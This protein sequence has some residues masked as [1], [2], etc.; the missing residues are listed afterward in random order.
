[1]TTKIKKENHKMS[2]KLVQIMF[3][4]GAGSKVHNYLVVSDIRFR[5]LGRHIVKS[6]NILK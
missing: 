3:H 5:E 6:K 1:M 2:T 4:K